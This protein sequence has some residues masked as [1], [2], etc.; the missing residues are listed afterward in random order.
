METRR[1]KCQLL[2]GQYLLDIKPHSPTQANDF[3]VETQRVIGM[4]RRPTKVQFVSDRR[5]QQTASSVSRL[6]DNERR[7]ERSEGQTTASLADHEIV[8]FLLRT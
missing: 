8:P 6:I 3:R 7:R 2:V 4:G 5:E 1:E